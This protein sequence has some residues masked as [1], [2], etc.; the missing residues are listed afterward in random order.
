[1]QACLQKGFVGVWMRIRTAEGT[2]ET[3]ASAGCG[4]ASL[5]PSGVTF[6]C[7]CRCV[8]RDQH[9]LGFKHVPSRLHV[10]V[11]PELRQ[12]PVASGADGRRH[13]PRESVFTEARGSP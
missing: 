11:S 2:L 8:F 3:N 10:L 13:S 4:A 5:L 6:R 7:L 12:V 1:M 9:T